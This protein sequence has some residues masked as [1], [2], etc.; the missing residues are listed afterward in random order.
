M[1]T[2]CCCQRTPDKNSTE[3]Q[4]GGVTRWPGSR[5]RRAGGEFAGWV[6]P[7]LALVLMPKCPVCVAGYIALATGI[8]ISLPTAAFLRMLLI[9]LCVASLTFIARRRLRLLL[10]RLLSSS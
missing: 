5:L 2:H 3:T 6:L 8:G 9:V 1:K 4:A 10:A 7:S